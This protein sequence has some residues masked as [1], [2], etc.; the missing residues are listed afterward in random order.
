MT[1]RNKP[2]APK[3]LVETDPDEEFKPEPP[4]DPGDD[5]LVEVTPISSGS[6]TVPSGA[7]FYLQPGQSVVMKKSDAAFLAE[8][9]YAAAD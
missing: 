7:S 8:S 2:N 3:G 5:G 6:V 1:E 4:M 9:G